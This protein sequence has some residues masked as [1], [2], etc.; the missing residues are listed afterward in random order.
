MNKRYLYRSIALHIA[1]F[2]VLVIDLPFFGHD[3]ITMGQA[4]IIVDLKDIKL[5]EMTNLPPKAVL[6]KEDKKATVPEKSPL[7]SGQPKKP[8]NPIYLRRPK[9]PR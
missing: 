5:A 9:K 7:K 6:G 2:L 8:N 1:A 3:K 4:P